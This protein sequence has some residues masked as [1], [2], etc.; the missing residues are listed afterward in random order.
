MVPRMQ[1]DGRSLSCLHPARSSSGV[2]CSTL[3]RCQTCIWVLAID[4]VILIG[5]ASEERAFPISTLQTRD[6][7][8]NHFDPYNKKIR[9]LFC[10]PVAKCPRRTRTP[11]S[12]TRNCCDGESDVVRRPRTF[13]TR[14]FLTRRP[15][16]LGIHRE[17]RVAPG[18]TTNRVRGIL[19]RI[20]GSLR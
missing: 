9:A 3:R 13:I 19:Q 12:D 8:A 2:F 14:A 18:L 17:T 11:A 4:R 7:T 6:G 16:S 1:S 10:Q 20:D 5:R 15:R